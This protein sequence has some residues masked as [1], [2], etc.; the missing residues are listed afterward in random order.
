MESW[1]KI[2]FNPKSIRTETIPQG[3]KGQKELSFIFLFFDDSREMVK[4]LFRTEHYS[5]LNWKQ[6]YHSLNWMRIRYLGGKKQACGK[7][8]HILLSM[9]HGLCHILKLSNRVKHAAPVISNKHQHK[10][11]G[12][13]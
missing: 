6:R 3:N 8:A 11:S 5:S 2:P 13:L 1:D 10:I 9:K 12:I 4:V 7:I